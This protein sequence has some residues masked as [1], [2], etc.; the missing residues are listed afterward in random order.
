MDMIKRDK[1]QR[2]V[3][4]NMDSER[5]NKMNEAKQNLTE[6]ALRVVDNVI[7]AAARSVEEAANPIRNI[8]WITHGEFTVEEGHKQID[9]FVATW[10]FN[11]YWVHYTKFVE[12]KDLI[13]SFHYIYHVYWSVPTAL[14]PVAKVSALAYFTIKFNKSKPPDMPVD[15]LYFFEGSSLIHRPGMSQFREQWLDDIIEAKHVLLK[16]IHF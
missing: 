2:T 10:E 8:K 1:S 5:Q 14:R 4:V 12:K 9:Q 11:N 6:V 3:A 7:K 16:M 15:V 13:H